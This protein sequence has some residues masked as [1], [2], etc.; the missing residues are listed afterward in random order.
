M[1]AQDEVA[2]VGA[3]KRSVA[4]RKV[5]VVGAAKAPSGLRLRL[6]RLR[7]EWARERREGEERKSEEG[8]ALAATIGAES[9]SMPGDGN[10]AAGAENIT[11]L[12]NIRN[13]DK[14]RCSGNFQIWDLE[15][16][17]E[18]WTQTQFRYDVCICNRRENT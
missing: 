5:L 10:A 8:V 6:R 11:A 2:N 17:S 4:R 1:G 3:R 7:H 16:V 18:T 13:L 15:P 14:P 9:G 12:L